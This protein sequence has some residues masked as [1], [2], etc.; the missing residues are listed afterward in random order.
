MCNQD[1]PSS[2]TEEHHVMYSPE[3]TVT[4]CVS[5]HNDIHADNGRHEELDPRSGGTNWV[6]SMHKEV[7][8]DES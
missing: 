3:V 2:E 4:V 1:F 8:D 7:F 6:Q 5:C